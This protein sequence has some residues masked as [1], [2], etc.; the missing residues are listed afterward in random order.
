MPVPRNLNE[1]IGRA[2]GYE[3]IDHHLRA[4]HVCASQPAAPAAELTLIAGV[5]GARDG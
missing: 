2:V 3:L 5:C 4:M 1:V